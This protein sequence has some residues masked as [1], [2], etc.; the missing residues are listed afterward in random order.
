MGAPWVFGI[1]NLRE[2]ARQVGMSIVKNRKTGDLYRDYRPDGIIGTPLY[3][4]YS[5]CTLEGAR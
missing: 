3:G 5:L 1:G 4:Y 2:L